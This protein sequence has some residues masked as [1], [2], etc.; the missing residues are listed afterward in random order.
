[1][2]IGK[3]FVLHVSKSES[4]KFQFDDCGFKPN[5]TQALNDAY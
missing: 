4:L 2:V 5:N 3:L 1:M